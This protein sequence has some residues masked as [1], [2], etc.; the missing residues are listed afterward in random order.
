MRIP[1]S[2]LKE[3]VDITVPAEVLA[4]RLTLAGLEVGEI[5][6]IGVP[7]NRIA[8][9]PHSMSAPSNHL[10][11]DR[12]K[13]V[14][15]KIVEVRSHPDADRLVLAMVDYGG[16]EL[17]QCVT[18]APNLFAY[19]D[20]GPLSTP[21]WS[22]FAKE[23]AEVWDGHSNEPKRMI[24]QGRKLR[25]IYNR[26]MV[27]SEKELG[28]SDSHEG[29]LLLEP[30][31]VAGYAPGTPLQDVL[32][33]VIFDIELTPNLARCWSVIG[34][35]RE[36]AALL[37]TEVR[38]PPTE[39]LMQG[40]PI[41]GRVDI[42]ITNPELNPRFTLALIENVTIRP[43]PQ[44][45]QMRLIKA[46][47]RP[48][49]NIVDIT[50]YVMLE[51]G[52]PLHAFDWDIVQRRAR[53]SGAKTPTIITRLPNPGER[54]TLLDGS[55]H[56]LDPF[57]VLVADTA[58]S[59]S[60]AGVMGGLESE[61]QPDSRNILLEAANWNFINI[62]RT[63]QARKITSEAGIRFSRGVHPSQAE[64]GLRRAAELMRVLG[65][66][67]VAQGI[68]DHYPLPPQPVVVD[69]TAADVSRLMGVDFESGT[70]A[71]I[72]RRLQFDVQQDGEKLTVTAPDHRLDI[73]TGL[74]G[75]ADLIEEIAR[76]YG[77]D[78]IPNTVI[79]DLLPPQ[80]NNPSLTYEE[81][82][83]DLL[84]QAGLREIISHRMT[85]PE[86]EGLLTPPGARS[87]LPD[88]GYVTLAN[89][90]SQDRTVM[91]H[92]L[93]AGLLSIAAANLRHADRLKLFEIGTVYLPVEGEEL[94]AEP[95][96]L[97]ILLS[98]PRDL[99]AWDLPA[100][101]GNIDFF[102]LKGVVERLLHG[103][104]LSDVA[105]V[106]A[107]H[108]TFFPGRIA[109]LVVNGREVGVMGE[110]H[111]KVRAAFDLPDD[112]PVVMAEFDLDAL[113]AAAR[114]SFIVKPVPTQPAVYQDIALVVTDQ[115]PAAE[116]ERVIREAG[117]ALLEDARL[118]DLYRG[119]PIPEGHKSL[120][121]ALT[122]RAPDRTLT[123]GDVAKVHQ[124]I[125]RAAERVLGA[126]LRA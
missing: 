78:R 115:T 46:G 23:G 18:G 22:P 81:W 14:L 34:V 106:P 112:L 57:N 95:R 109:A 83:R 117:G 99:S 121:Y 75:Q 101:P 2:W 27:C 64:V 98:G 116:V 107:Q 66:G 89:P 124:K 56:Q 9:L 86:Q 110:V 32:G 35:A 53:E 55:E 61:V 5:I 11:W 102:D 48:I 103:M 87:S 16:P 31:T 6:Y 17:E 51:V 42:Q 77:Y 123:D 104:H 67:T 111:P 79:D 63:M 119:D 4:E 105:F 122:Y 43:S 108:A 45:M 37:G 80:R 126:K 1:L 72:L 19:K 26:A 88:V 70:I 21:L 100:R 59:L 58:G 20:Q 49:N 93:M 30:E 3:Y 84:V 68:V 29:I 82:A 8:D 13:I 25:G 38:Q 85:T 7:Q 15:G 65:G 39:V 36:V 54:L 76:I 91:R 24:L 71:D 118:F 120:A 41:A 62:R 74:V 44:W 12:E 47:M 52:Q 125:V 92:T 90:I 28:L 33:D 50:N 10:I 73:G 113:L 96:R 69:L 97:G 40:A 94:P 114:P 60:L